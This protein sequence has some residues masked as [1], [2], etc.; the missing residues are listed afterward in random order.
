MFLM[1]TITIMLHIL[2]F[3]GHTNRTRMI[4]LTNYIQ[5]TVRMLLRTFLILTLWQRLWKKTLNKWIGLILSTRTMLTVIMMTKNI[6]THTKMTK[7][8]LRLTLRLTNLFTLTLTIYR[9]YESITK[10]RTQRKKTIN[11][12][13]S[14]S[15][16]IFNF[17]LT[18]T[19]YTTI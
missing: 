15:I 19:L 2:I 5:R 4:I 9:T 3:T 8:F 7:R 11:K 18:T 17:M 12:I 6:L 10:R 1:I 14:L 16:T 13:T